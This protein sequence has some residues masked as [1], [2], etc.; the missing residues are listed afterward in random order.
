[1]TINVNNPPYNTMADTAAIQTAIND[2]HLANESVTLPAKIYSITATLNLPY[3]V[4][5]VGEGAGTI[6][7]ASASLNG[8]MI[9]TTEDFYQ[10]GQQRYVTPLSQL[11]LNATDNTHDITLFQSEH[12]FTSCMIDRVNFQGNPAKQQRGF[13]ALHTN[14]GGRANFLYHNIFNACAF[15]DLKGSECIWFEGDS[16]A[17]PTRRSNNNYFLECRFTFYKTAARMVGIG[18]RFVSCLFN[19]PDNPVY[20]DPNHVLQTG[21]NPAGSDFRIVFEEG[22]NNTCE[23]CWFEGGQDQVLV[24]TLTIT[25][26]ETLKT[27]FFAPIANTGLDSTDEI[28]DLTSCETA[29]R[30]GSNTRK[31]SVSGNVTAKFAPGEV[32][33]LKLSNKTV[34]STISVSAVSGSNT[35]ITIADPLVSE[36]SLEVFSTA[37]KHRSLIVSES[38]IRVP[39]LTSDTIVASETMTAQYINIDGD[40]ALGRYRL[41]A[42]GA[43]EAESGYMRVDWKTNTTGNELVTITGGTQGQILY[44]RPFSNVRDLTI[45]HNSSIGSGAGTGNI[46]LTGGTD[47]VLDNTIK[48]LGLIYDSDKQ[49][50]LQIS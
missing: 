15:Q 1:M 41:D 28:A 33:W 49:R 12:H 14:S 29:S 32:I 22:Y 42:S 27:P 13:R 18:N 24:S 21:Q 3:S 34:K 11:V 38:L 17:S 10:V 39:D 26:S 8:P 43:I 48:L 4:S 23:G 25:S 19:Q 9:K 46:S 5:L 35:V 30:V 37:P 20:I 50:W 7:K 36:T 45:K 31:I 16:T 40:R 2:A 44:L 6:L 47:L